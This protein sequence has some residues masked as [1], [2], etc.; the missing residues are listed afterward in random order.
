MTTK[1]VA[2]TKGCVTVVFEKVRAL[3][4]NQLGFDEDL[5]V[6]TTDLAEELGADSLDLVELMM[7]VEEEFSLT[8][9]EE[10][11]AAFRTV[12]DVVKYIE[13]RI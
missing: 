11:V 8:I 7:S 3:L 5:I 9:E 6:E 10:D 2:V 12:A 1:N 13:D 4:A